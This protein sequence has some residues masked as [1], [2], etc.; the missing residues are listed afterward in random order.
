MPP[1]FISYARKTSAEAA[2]ALHA[3]LEDDAFFDQEDIAAGDRFPSRIV[4]ALLGSRVVVVFPDAA[5][6]HQQFCRW[7]LQTALEPFARNPTEGSLSHLIVVPPS[8][9]WPSELDRFPPGIQN[10]NWRSTDDTASVVALIRKQL[11]RGCTTLGER[12]GAVGQ[13]QE[14]VRAR[15]LELSTHPAPE[16]L[17]G[18]RKFPAQLPPSKGD[19]FVGRSD[20]LWRIDFALGT[21]RGGSSAAAL[22]GT[23]EGAGGVGK[24]QLALEYVHRFGR[25]RF[26]GG[27]LWVDAEEDLESQHHGILRVLEPHVPDLPTF[28]KDRRNAHEELAD[29]LNR[30]AT[31]ADILFV[32]DN[33]PESSPE[34]LSTWC[35]ALNIVTVLATSRVRLSATEPAVPVPVGVLASEAAVQLL[36]SGLSFPAPA[37]DCREVAEWVG[38]LP[39]ALTVLNATLRLQGTTIERLA[40]KARSMVG[41]AGVVDVHVDDL[42][43]GRALRGVTEAFAESYDALTPDAQRGARQLARLAPSAIPLELV[44]ALELSSAVRMSLTRCSFVTLDEAAGKQSLP[45]LGSMHRVLADYLHERSEHPE[46]EWELVRKALVVVLTRACQSTLDWEL[47]QAC[48]AHSQHVFRTKPVTVDE[49]HGGVAELASVLGSCLRMLAR[50]EEAAKVIQEAT[51]IRRK[52]AATWPDAFLKD[53]AASLNSLSVSQ[54]SLGRREEGLRTVQEAVEV[55]RTLSTTKAEEFRPKLAGSLNN[56]SVCLLQMR[57]REEGLR[58]AQ[59]AVQ[60]YRELARAKSDDFLPTLAM[61][62]HNLSN[63]LAELKRSAEGLTAVQEAVEIRRDLA[64]TDPDAFLP[65]L[66]SSLNHLSSR[67]GE[68]GRSEEGLTAVRESV[69]I[70]RKLAEARPAAFLPNLASSLNNLSSRLGAV[71]RSEEGL[72]AAQESVEIR[73]R[74]A[75]LRPAVFRLELALSLNTLS[76]RLGEL[77]RSEE[78][79]SAVQEAVEVLQALADQSPDTFLSELAESLRTL[80]K[81]LSELRRWEEALAA[82]R[83]AVE[84]GRQLA[85]QLPQVFLSKLAS[86]LKD[87]AVV[88]EQLGH[89]DES[90]AA[91]DEAKTLLGAAAQ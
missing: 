44:D 78:G 56:L 1:V 7:E 88:L 76:D 37:E 77:G 35:P 4:D 49:P 14:S 84:V 79:L 6:F 67:L 10:S 62:L 81:R 36:T 70:R 30:A 2:R 28:R 55:Y 53:L 18:I 71:G 86:S 42:P 50:P 85:A 41:P 26:P 83:R 73:R 51:E 46:I 47:M 32:V 27:I 17:A 21:L 23:I 89:L 31:G 9:N 16:S 34:P 3:A 59:E 25:R 66:A 63:C 60:L 15:L 38:R 80:S 75:E 61:A 43:P 24:T 65:N 8:G 19:R 64:R 58:A 45:V 72:T 57:R 5:Y 54:I 13:S 22:I 29:A 91:A 90:R 48:V 82:M 74:L 12:Y 20:D 87:L 52:L 40:N 11:E 68:I 33:L 39:L 69:A